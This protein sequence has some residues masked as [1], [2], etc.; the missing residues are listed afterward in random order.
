MSPPKRSHLRTRRLADF[1]PLVQRIVASGENNDR[2]EVR[3]VDQGRFN[4][5]A[6]LI[7][8]ILNDAWS[9]NWGFVPL[10]P[11]RSPTPARS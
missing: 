2:I 1:P 3:K 5:E 7:L 9:D 10:H 11:P 6:T 8:D 4:E